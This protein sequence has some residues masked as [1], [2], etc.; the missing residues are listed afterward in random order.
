MNISLDFDDTYTRDP[1]MWDKFIELAHS[2]GHK[3]YCVTAR[4]DEYHPERDEV[5]ETI[6]KLIGK[7]RCIFTC[8]RAKRPET[9]KHKISIDVWIDDMPDAIT[10]NNRLFAN[11]KDLDF[12]Y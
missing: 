10:E 9:Y 7:E 6:G 5:Y 11:L 4:C 8:G 3:V 1:Y 2:V 12:P